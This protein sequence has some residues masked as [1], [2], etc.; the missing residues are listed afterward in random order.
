MSLRN[1]HIRTWLLTLTAMCAFAGNSLLCRWA[2]KETSIDPVSFTLIRIISGAFA[3]SLILRFRKI[4]CLVSGNWASAFA[5]F[6]YMAAFSYAYIG[7]PTGTGA[8]LLFGAVQLTMVMVGL[9]GGERFKLKQSLGFVIAIAGLAWLLL[10]STFTPPIKEST[11]MLIAGVAWAIYSLRGQTA[12]DPIAVTAG[13]FMRAA[14]F[15][16]GFSLMFI[17]SAKLD[18]LGSLLAIASGVITSA[19]GYA[20]WYS[21]LPKLKITHAAVIQLSVPVIATI[22]GAILLNE[23]I[24]YRLVLSSIATLGGVGIVILNKKQR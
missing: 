13:N 20:L 4:R 1:T 16:V 5:L 18:S 6:I 21:V 7:L 8:F 24:T 23:T 17:S 19:I 2:L 22:A 9:W 12:L 15:G 11:V 10:P 14:A 3:L